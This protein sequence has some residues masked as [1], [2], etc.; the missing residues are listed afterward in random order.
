M[1]R[2]QYYF[3]GRSSRILMDIYRD[4]SAVIAY[5]YAIIHMDDYFYRIAKTCR[6]FIHAIIYNFINKVVQPLARGRAYIHCRS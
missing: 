6:C 2:C 5:G 3:S 4:A 1:E